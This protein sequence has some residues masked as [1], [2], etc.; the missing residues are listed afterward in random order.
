MGLAYH[1][2]TNFYHMSESYN[3]TV[4]SF[5]DNGDN[6]VSHSPQGLFDYKLTTPQRFIGSLAFIIGTR[7][8]ISG[9]Y[10]AVDYSQSNYR[11]SFP[12]DFVDANNTIHAIYRSTGNLRIGAEYK[13][14]NISLRGGYALYGSPYADKIND[15]ART[16]YTFGLGFR[17]D[18]FFLDLATVLTY[19]S[20]KYYFY[21]LE[22]KINPVVNKT[23]NQTYVMTM[24]IRF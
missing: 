21:Q 12:G 20:E 15:G 24:G 2:P 22:N 7:G 11:S 10:E 14:D 6:F 3:T 23:H 16:S 8:F 19:A 13:L 18:S 4:S 5:F 1:S 17:S 9:E